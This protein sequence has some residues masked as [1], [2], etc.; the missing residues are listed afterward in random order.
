MARD[1]DF[2]DEEPYVVIEK[3]SGSLSSFMVG[4]AIGA[5][6]ALLFAPQSGDATR[7]DIKRRARRAGNAAQ[8]VA[9]D[10]TGTVADTFD[11]ARRRVEERIDTARQA[12]ELKKRQ[13]HR[14]M[15][16][17]REAAHQAREELER[18]IA[19]T[20]AAYQAGGDVARAARPAASAPA[21]TAAPATLPLDGAEDEA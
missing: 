19:E 2:D 21:R 3:H 18:R 7:R 1:F 12:L 8:Q 9:S 4:L 6:L 15:E 14:A 17:G 13:V 16:A 10:V 11:S 20:K 5:G